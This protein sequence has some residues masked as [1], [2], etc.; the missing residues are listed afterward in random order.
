MG[1]RVSLAFVWL[2]F[3]LTVS[4]FAAES[5]KVKL[6]GYSEYRM[7]PSL[8]VDGQR[9]VA[10]DETKVKG[11]KGRDLKSVPLGYEVKV[12]GVRR[13][14]GSVLATK[15][16][17]KPNGEAMFEG[18]VVSATNQIE[19]MWVEAGAMY[20]EGPRGRRETVG[21]LI[22][23]GPDVNRVRRIM[24]RLVPPYVKPTDLRVRVVDTKEWNASA[25]GNGAIWV[26]RGLL[27]ELS[28]DEAAIILGHELA[29]YTHEH[30]RRG[31]RKAMWG[32]LAGLAGMLGAG[33][34]GSNAGRDAA[35]MGAL[36]SVTAWQSG[37]SRDLEDQA[38]R[39]G[40]RYAHEGGFDVSQGPA[41]WKKFR[42]KYG[43]DSAA[44]NFLFGSHSR[45]SDRIRNLE[46]ELRVNYPDALE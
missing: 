22:D 2:A 11:A 1:T 32:Q 6:E 4:A 3:F 46:R 15:V 41:L 14:D 30:S 37:Y 27:R 19:R 26:Y 23:E 10:D 20:M 28:D 45:P 38:D 7:G 8:V 29:H 9:I 18:D 39:V 25:M 36:L 33:A 13:R 43:E 35:T 40:L 34:I 44:T 31:A 17:V 42:K 16:E 21:E 5:D 12:E 24:A